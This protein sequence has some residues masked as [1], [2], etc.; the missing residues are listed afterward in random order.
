M[1]CPEAQLTASWRNALSSSE[2]VS[3]SLT[4]VFS[5]RF[6]RGIGNSFMRQMADVNDL[7]PFPVLNSLTV[8]LRSEARRRDDAGYQSLWAGQAAKLIRRMPAKELV[9][10]LVREMKESVAEMAGV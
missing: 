1:G 9:E 3:T 8:L 4:D 7:P 6:A 5:G 2:D 10:A